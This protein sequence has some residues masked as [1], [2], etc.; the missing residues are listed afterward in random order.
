MMATIT[1]I[2]DAIPIP[3]CVD[4]NEKLDMVHVFCPKR[5]IFKKLK[6][7]AGHSLFHVP[8]VTPQP[9]PA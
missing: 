6:P 8:K 1:A 4:E 7:E 5:T 3:T 9:L 2:P